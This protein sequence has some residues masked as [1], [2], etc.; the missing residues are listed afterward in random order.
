M[1]VLYDHQAFRQTY[2]GMS[3]YF[4][5]LIKALQ[6]MDGF[7]PCVP[8]YFTDNE[9][10]PTRRTFI[11]PRH[12]PGKTRAAGILNRTISHRALRTGFDLFHPTY[13]DPYFLSQVLTPFVVT[14]HDMIHEIFN[15]SDVRE[16]GF[17]MPLLSHRPRV[18]CLGHTTRPGAVTAGRARCIGQEAAGP[19]L[20]AAVGLADP[21]GIPCS[22]LPGRMSIFHTS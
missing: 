19:V 3:R 18:H 1:R 22:R 17:G 7:E 11:V 14:V 21:R 10:L 9:Y 15:E 4:V 20:L 8:R 5:E 16:D 13:L 2:G 12:F 6:A